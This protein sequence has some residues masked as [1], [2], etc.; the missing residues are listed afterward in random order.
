MM[1]SHR[2]IAAIVVLATM[3]SLLSA[4]HESQ[5][6]AVEEKMTV[7][8]ATPAEPAPETTVLR[9]ARLIDGMGGPV[10]ENATVVVSNGFVVSAGQPNEF[11]TPK[12]AT[13]ID[14][15]GKTVLP[16]LISDHSHLGLVDGTTAGSQNYSRANILRQLAQFEAY[17]VTTVTSLGLNGELFY[18]VQGDMRAG[19]VA[20][21]DFFG[22]DRG[23]GVP[24]AAPPVKVDSAQVYRPTT[25]DEARRMVRESAERGPTLLKIWVDDFHGTEAQ[26]MSPEIYSAII[27][28]A[29]RAHLRVAAHVYYLDDAKRLVAAGIDILAHG[30]R[31]RLVDDELVQAMKSHGTWYVATLQLDESFFVYAEHPA[32]MDSEFF[33]H[34]V[35]PA[36]AAQFADPKWREKTLTDTAQISPER[37]ALAVGSQNL[38]RLHDAG[39]KIGFGTDSGANPLRIP[40]LAEHRELELMTEAGLAPLEAIH[41]ATGNAAALLGLEDRG[42]LGPGKLADFLV[43]DGRPDVRIGDID[44][45]VAVWHRGRKVSGSPLEF[46]P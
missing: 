35:Q 38:K 16:G 31:D 5:P 7:R 28:E 14:L 34:A 23:L 3:G 12:G 8:D 40:G 33:K 22:A 25:P 29:H 44:H 6:P 36:L 15:A 45:I 32:W 43:V 10:V 21:A 20:G 19:R 11:E 46:R 4:C 18:E 1:P 27:D 39:V 2:S 17:G 9:G 37:Q 26:K 24:Q 13:V 42:A 41:I 30:V